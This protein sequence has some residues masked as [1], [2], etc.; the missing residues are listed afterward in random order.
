MTL[1]EWFAALQ[2]A[3]EPLGVEVGPETLGVWQD[4]AAHGADPLPVRALE[5]LGVWSVRALAAAED[6]ERPECTP[7]PH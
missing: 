6:G 2:A 4:R 5:R 7:P 1:A 3:L